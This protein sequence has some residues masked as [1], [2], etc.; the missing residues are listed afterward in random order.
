MRAMLAKQRRTYLCREVPPNV[1]QIT[2]DAVQ[3]TYL[4]T[5]LV[6]HTCAELL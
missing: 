6:R 3:L 2:P 1:I 4:S 5:C